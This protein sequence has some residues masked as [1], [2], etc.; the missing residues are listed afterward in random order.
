M[1]YTKR[2]I[3]QKRCLAILS[4]F[5]F[6]TMVNYQINNDY[7]TAYNQSEP[8]SLRDLKENESELIVRKYQPDLNI[9]EHIDI[10]KYPIYKSLLKNHA[11]YDTLKGANKIEIYE[12]Y[13]HKTK[14]EIYCIIKFG[15]AVNGF[16][17]VI[18]GGKYIIYGIFLCR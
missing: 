8:I 7:I 6:I 15:N 12:V 11:I 13:K 1:F 3:F 4:Q 5:S 17:K 14:N 10:H 18:H 9:Y 16:P 2:F